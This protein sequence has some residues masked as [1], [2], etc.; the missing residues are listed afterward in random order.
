MVNTIFGHILRITLLSLIIICSNGSRIYAD[1]QPTQQHQIIY[2]VNYTPLKIG[3]IDGGQPLIPVNLDGSQAAT[4][5]VDTGT[6][7]SI[8]SSELVKQMNLHLEPGVGGDGKPLLWK[9]KQAMTTRVPVL[10]VGNIR[11]TDVTLLVLD[12]KEISL[13]PD[14]NDVVPYQG[15]IGSNLLQQFAVVLDS[16][17]LTFGFCVP[18]NLSEHQIRLFGMSQPYVLPMT[19]VDTNNNLLQK[20]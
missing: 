15:I 20:S 8:I 7:F 14:G 17:K 19:N 2:Q 5:L 16:Q 12:A 13:S 6:T 11:F 9:G 4:F 1:D 18:G 10:K 3:Q